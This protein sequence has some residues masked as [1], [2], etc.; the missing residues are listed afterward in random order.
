MKHRLAVVLA[1]WV[2][3]LF[4]TAC[5]S[6]SQ[7]PPPAPPDLQ[8]A[9]R[10]AIAEHDALAV[11]EL[12]RRGSP[13]DPDAL[14]REAVQAGDV[15]LLRLLL[16]T[17]FDVNAGVGGNGETVLGAA[18]RLGNRAVVEFLLANGANPDGRF[19]PAAGYRP[20]YEAV[21]LN[22]VGVAAALL[23]AGADPNARVLFDPEGKPRRPDDGPTVLML[24]TAMSGPEMVE[25][26]LA[27][28]ADP[29]L[30]D[31]KQRTAMQWIDQRR[32]PADE[33]RTALEK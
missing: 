25:L 20:L 31:W 24:A 19:G 28:G 11:A 16:R 14:G 4:A 9:L 17:G 18:A 26:L 1:A 30:K 33:I 29:G 2:A 22:H 32:N 10:T 21:R 6:E 27:W 15:S 7:L 13:S 23:K 8:G 12:L 5:R 3:V